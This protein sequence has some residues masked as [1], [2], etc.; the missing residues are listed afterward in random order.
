M[1]DRTKSLTT[2]APFRPP[3]RTEAQTADLP[4]R[5]PRITIPELLSTLWIAVLFADVLRGVHEILR[6]GFVDELANEGT[7]YGRVV[8]DATLFWS[9]LVLAF[10]AS[11]VVLARVLPRRSNRIVNIIA[12]V[13]MI[14]GVLFSWPKDPDDFVFGTVQILGAVIVITISARW[15]D[16]DQPTADLVDRADR[17]D[18]GPVSA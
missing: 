14:G 4:W 7:N 1:T 3:P 10:I 12:G 13:M 5:H 2:P 17:I 9:G 6:P 18:A 15:R 8:T 11:V 16:L